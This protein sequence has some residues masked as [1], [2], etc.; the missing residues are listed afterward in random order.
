MGLGVDREVYVTF[1]KDKE[2]EFNKIYESLFENDKEYTWVDRCYPEEEAT[3]ED[4]LEGWR[5]GC[6]I[7]EDKYVIDEFYGEKEGDDSILWNALASIVDDDSYINSWRE[8]HC[9]Y[10]WKFKD[11]KLEEIWK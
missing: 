3:I 1:S 7:K 2:K 10:E 4:K 9:D 6:H 5:Y 11:G 8:D